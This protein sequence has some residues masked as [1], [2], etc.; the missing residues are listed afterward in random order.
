MQVALRDITVRFG[1]VTALDG[2]SLDVASGRVLAV[3]GENGAGKSTLM[4]VLFGLLRPHAGS[5]AIAGREQVFRSPQDAIAAGIGM[6]H[7]H[8]MLQD[9]M[10]VLENIVLGAEPAGRFGIVDFAAARDRFERGPARYGIAVDLNARVAELA[11]GE[12]Q[13]VG[14][15]R[16]LW[17]DASLMILDEPTA[18]LD[19]VEKDRLVAMVKTLAA[20]GKTIVMVTHRLDE[21]IATADHVAVMRGGRLVSARPAVATSREL[22]A[23]EIVGGDVP[24]PARPAPR[25]PGDAVLKVRD[26]LLHGRRG[27]A[28]TVGPLSF[29]VRRG[30][31]VGIAGVTGNGQAELVEALTGLAAVRAGT[32]AIAGRRVETLSVRERRRAGLGHV[33][34]DR[35]RRGL[36]LAATVTDNANAG[37]DP[38]RFRNGP[39]LDRGAMA[40]YA[41]GLI[42]AYR[43][44]VAG[45]DAVAGTMSGGNQQKLVAARELTR[46][47]AVVIAE[48]PAS[49]IDIG[50]VDLI[51]RELMRLRD[52]GGAVLLVS[53]DLDEIL[54]LCDRILVMYGGTL[55][56]PLEAAHADRGRIGMLMTSGARDGAAP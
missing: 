29:D 17:R 12:K 49:G 18:V 16:M 2:V 51:H 25:P 44:T 28:G 21:V 34:Q 50:A 3:V 53:S 36:A 23:R 14:I 4:N 32:I 35:R 5:I 8:V 47:P 7:Q 48:D 1:A 30:E 24:R 10:T 55:S 38:R 45:P 15:L 56:A 37:R 39:F 22:I 27:T 52:C 40:R 20:A 54:L 43:I 9:R 46:A 6:V 42:D 31:I 11:A 26:V 41:R 33:P 19:P 13:A